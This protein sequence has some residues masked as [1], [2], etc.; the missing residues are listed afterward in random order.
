MI[1][2]PVPVL[3]PL[4]G[5]DRGIS[6]ARARE[7]CWTAAFSPPGVFS[8][9][10]DSDRE[11]RRDGGRVIGGGAGDV[12]ISL[13]RGLSRGSGGELDFHGILAHGDRGFRR[14]YAGR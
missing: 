3:L 8:L 7:D 6:R 2:S 11:L 14:G 4:P 1:N 9:L 13:L 12:N 10:Q 5:P